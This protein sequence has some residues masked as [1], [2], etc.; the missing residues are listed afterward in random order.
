MP[1]VAHRPVSR[2]G[3]GAMTTILLA[4]VLLAASL[5]P[6][7]VAQEA[8][9]PQP[10]AAES[11]SGAELVAA[12]LGVD[13]DSASFYEL[14][15][16][17]RSLGLAESG[18][19]K[20]LQERLRGHYG[21]PA[22]E[23]A[24]AAARTVTVRSARSAEYFT[25]EQ[26]DESYLV[27]SGDVVVELRDPEAGATHTVHAGRLTFNQ[28]R[29]MLSAAGGVRYTLEE[30]G[31]TETFE[32]RSLSLDLD[33]WEASFIDGRTSKT[34][35]RGDR[36]IP[37]TFE[38]ASI[39]RLSN[40][41]V[42]LEEGRFTS[43]DLVDPH[44][45]VRARKVW[46]LAAG[47]WAMRDAVLTVGRV[48][49]FWMPY[50]FYPGDRLVFNPSF[51]F[52]QR[53][54]AYVQTTTYL[55][56]RREETE[57]LFSFL[58]V[59][60][61]Q[62]TAYEQELRGIFLRKLPARAEP[63]AA[64]ASTLKLMIDVYSRLGMFLGLAG[65]FP[66]ST[67]FKGGIGFSRTLFVDPSTGLAT[68]Y[69]P[70]GT[71]SETYW[72]SSSLFGA[73]VPFRYGFEGDMKAASGPWSG[74]L[75]Y[76]LF[77]DPA[78]TS[79]FYGRS[80]G[81]RLSETLTPVEGAAAA[82]KGSLAWELTNRF[83]FSKSLAS[84]GIRTLSVPY[85][86]GRFT[87]LSRQQDV[88]ANTPEAFDPGRTFYY[89]S[90]IAA[91]NA[92]LSLSGELLRLGG[93]SGPAAQS[94]TPAAG[95]GGVGPGKGYRDPFAA[96]E[97]RPVPE[98]SAP[99]G[100]FDLRIPAP[101]PA[102]GRAAAPAGPS[103]AV[104]YQMAPRAALEHA[105]DAK[106]WETPADIDLGIL[107]GTFETAGTG[108][109]QAAA[110]LAGNRL[111]LAVSLGFDSLWRL[112]FARSPTLSDTEWTALV[113]RDVQQDRLDFTS[114]LGA[115]LRPFEPT[116]ALA[117]STLSWRLGMRLVQVRFAGGDPLDPQFAART[118]DFT[119]E[120][121]S[122]HSLAAAIPF[123]TQGFSESLTLS[124]VL[125][126]MAGSLAARLDASAWILTAR[127]Q[128]SAKG[129]W[130]DPDSWTAQPLAVGLT[131][132]PWKGISLS[133]ELSF[134][135]AAGILSRANTTLRAGGFSAFFA[136]EWMQP[137][138]WRTVPTPDFYP[139][140][141][142][143]ERLVPSTVRAGYEGAIG[144]RWAW[145]DRVQ[146]EAGLRTSWRMN[147]Q[148]Y[149][150]NLFEFAPRLTLKVHELLDLSFSSLSTNTKT[151]RYLPGFAEALGESWVNPLTDLVRSFNVFDT[152]P[153]T[154]N[155]RYLSSFKI[156][157]VSL[158]AVHHLHDWDLSVEY[159]GAPKL[160]T[161][162]VRQ[163]VWSPSFAV[164]LQWLAVPE[165][166]AK[167]RGDR[168]GIAVRQ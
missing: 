112:R 105:F 165:L 9:P 71:G 124:A 155:D 53:E 45:A 43:C 48:P 26:A 149:T 118:L 93:A 7:A 32:G 100:R 141:P 119:K 65:A 134:D 111:D 15:A 95:G 66:P 88:A 50:F 154:S 11:R 101:R 67:S 84:S 159:T 122:E 162:P 13:I 73:T 158:K 59:A 137:L 56:G 136:L 142:G 120:T 98:G 91:P 2:E 46:I 1:A 55:L 166:T 37:F 87:W 29:G 38:G 75:H 41:Q 57:G 86:N 168:E 99:P 78:F 132:E 164:Q 106:E 14:V 40:D 19:R 90:S 107:Y 127:V 167:V 153:P 130:T 108:R 70:Y 79:D 147:L 20:E 150:D 96:A 152:D 5:C 39:S 156:R 139:A 30:G 148:R 81:L 72:N 161:E 125:P 23:A 104:T 144:T 85:L 51:G 47:E 12:T 18:S 92:S 116:S 17:C 131:A 52:R 80:E 110:S 129:D 126:P 160:V 24:A 146:V 10:N 4:V 49:V 117:G 145:K 34:Q 114:S 135:A 64:D 77:S 27:L 28:A 36:Q 42:V 123:R 121:T 22:P 68:P 8:T 31:R 54:G 35:S 157:S 94:G 102:A 128:A 62:G 44:Y 133:E 6:P 151:Y 89:P 33:T 76:E 143:T 140:G 21:L 103:L 3:A 115:T 113:Q 138:E 69:F 60:E 163:Y 74:S 109:V 61:A 97:Q 63:E 16:W 82:A 83:D 58:K 25:I